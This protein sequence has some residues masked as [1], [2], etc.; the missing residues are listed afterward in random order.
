MSSALPWARSTLSAFSRAPFGLPL[1][2]PFLRTGAL[3]RATLSFPGDADLPG[4]TEVLRPGSSHEA[5]V[6]LGTAES[7][8]KP[9]FVHTID[10]RL[11]DVYGAGRHQDFLLA[12]SGDGAP[13]HHLL[14]PARSPADRLY[15]SLWLYLAGRRPVVVGILPGD[16]SDSDELGEGSQ[17]SFALSGVVGRFK[18]VGDLGLHGAL[19]PGEAAGLVMSATNDGGGLRALPPARFFRERS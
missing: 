13:L 3:H 15:S 14:L 4:G 12:N 19:A 5:V 6:R 16:E 18:A 11:P 9:P 8:D 10:I 7:T 2:S 17:V 1:V